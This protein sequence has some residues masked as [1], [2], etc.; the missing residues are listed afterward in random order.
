MTGLPAWILSISSWISI[1]FLVM[2]HLPPAFH[3]SVMPSGFL[4]AI[5]V[6]M[7]VNNLFLILVVDSFRY[8]VV[9]GFFTQY[10]CSFHGLIISLR[11]GNFPTNSS[12]CFPM[13]S[14]L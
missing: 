14:G 5:R 11:S 7:P 9:D 3:V 2:L 10:A 8:G 12:I 4:L 13:A 1:D 6:L